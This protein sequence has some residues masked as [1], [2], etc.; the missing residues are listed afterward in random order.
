M[1]PTRHAQAFD[2]DDFLPGNDRERLAAGFLRFA[3]DED[4]AAAALFEATTEF[5]SHQ[6]EMVAQN[7]EQRGLFVRGY[8]DRL[9]IHLQTD[10]LHRRLLATLRRHGLV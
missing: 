8:A 5:G 10:W 6:T 3:V 1:W 2:R 4:H 9:A 7:I